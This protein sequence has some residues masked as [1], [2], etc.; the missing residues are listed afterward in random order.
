MEPA[1]VV[2]IHPGQWFSPFPSR[3]LA[4]ALI[5]VVSGAHPEPLAAQRPSPDSTTLVREARSAQDRFERIRLQHLPPTWWS[6]SGACDETVGRFCVRFSGSDREELRERELRWVPVPE[7]DPIRE[8]RAALLVDLDRI[9]QA[10]PGDDWVAGQRVAYHLESGDGEGALAAARGCAGDEAWCRSLEG[11]ALHTL[12]RFGEAEG[13]FRA[14]LALL[15]E[16]ERRERLDPSALVQPGSVGW[17]RRGSP[18]E[19][20]PRAEWFWQLVNPLVLLDGNALFTG[21]LARQTLARTRDNARNPHSLRWGDDLTELLVRY[22]EVRTFREAR[23]VGPARA[24]APPSAVGYYDPAAR[25]FIPQEGAL[26]DPLGSTAHEWPTDLRKTRSRHVIPGFYR[27]FPL[28]ATAT[29]FPRKDSILVVVAW[30]LPPLRPIPPPETNDPWMLDPTPPPPFP[31]GRAWGGVGLLP[32]RIDDDLP[33]EGWVRVAE[34]GVAG[35]ERGFFRFTIPPG[36]HLLSVEVVDGEGG[37]AWRYREGFR[38]GDWDESGLILSDL[39]LL[40]P[41]SAA[42]GAPPPSLDAVLPRVLGD[43]RIAPGMVEVAWEVS[44]IP[45]VESELRFHLSFRREDRGPLRRA[46]EFLRLLRPEPPV[47][48]RW[49]EGVDPDRFEGGGAPYLRTALLDLSGIPEGEYR[50]SLALFLPGLGTVLS[51]RVVEVV[52]GR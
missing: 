13:V 31:P 52:E 43:P 34:N 28:Q 30:S 51:S 23:D 1:V 14:A 27:V 26:H 19:R 9:A 22:G 42:P 48:I 35:V 16:R 3:L 24:M 39:L 11:L 8:A 32:I 45:N 15:P 36:D 38:G 41:D 12:G 6:A 47:E 44:G 49:A 33:G 20:E 25:G 5:A 10:L 21:H 50:I 17:V 4:A 7:P 40:A 46:G 29:R 2:R 18:E 37:R